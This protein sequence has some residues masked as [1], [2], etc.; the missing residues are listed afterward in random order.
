MIAEIENLNSQDHDRDLRVKYIM[1]LSENLRKQK[2]S[3]VLG[4]DQHLDYINNKTKKLNSLIDSLRD[5]NDSFEDIFPHEKEDGELFINKLHLL[6]SGLSL[7][8]AN[9]SKEIPKDSFKTCLDKLN[10]ENNQIVEYIED[11]NEF[12]LSEGENNLLDDLD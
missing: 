12:I 7:A 11:L 1:H 9:L 8:I 5:F 10:V 6:H 3:F 4:S 2:S